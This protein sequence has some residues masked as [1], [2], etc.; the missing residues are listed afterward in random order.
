MADNDF[1]GWHGTTIIGV[2]KDG[3]I[4]IAGD[5]QVSLGQTVI[6]GTARKVRRLSPGGSEVV[7]GFAGS[8]AD[9]FTLLER[10]EAKL[11]ATPGQ[12]ARASVELAKDWRTDKY[13]QKLEAMLIVTD[14]KDMFVITGAGD[15]LEPEHNVAAIG[16]GGNFALAAARAMMDS[17]KSAEEVAR[18]AMA[19][20]ADICVYTN[21]KLTVETISG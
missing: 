9:A 18:Q 5:G 15:V 8:T 3:Q 10:L 4:V 16:S 13:L 21:G 2:K 14:G 20:A 6:K 19:I 17:D 11:E 1:P 7:A 12:L